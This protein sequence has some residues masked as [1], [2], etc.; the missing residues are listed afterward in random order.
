MDTE[1]SRL[2]AASNWNNPG[3][4][5]RVAAQA[6]ECPEGIGLKRGGG[7]KLERWP[8]FDE[9]Y[10]LVETRFGRSSP[11]PV[12]EL[13]VPVSDIYQ[14]GPYGRADMGATANCAEQW[15]NPSCA[16]HEL[17]AT[18]DALKRCRTSKMQAHCPA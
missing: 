11:T 1:N 16:F 7:K 10:E 3:L 12:R 15:P 13:S 2:S 18:I 6:T 5:T 4:K 14:A 8:P 17:V 9:L